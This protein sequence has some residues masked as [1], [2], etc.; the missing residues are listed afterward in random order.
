MH[1]GHLELLPV[2]DDWSL[3]VRRVAMRSRDAS[4]DNLGDVIVYP[5]A[6]SPKQ[7]LYEGFQRRYQVKS[8]GRRWLYWDFPTQFRAPGTRS[9]TEM[10][11][12]FGDH[13]IDMVILETAPAAK[14]I[15]SGRY[16]VKWV[17][18]DQ[19]IDNGDTFYYV[20]HKSETDR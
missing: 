9:R 19:L 3:S 1:P 20:F 10:E 11:A 13:L 7:I 15:P 6:M 12:D 8:I 16:Q 2:T 18:N 5:V 4:L 14:V 17:I